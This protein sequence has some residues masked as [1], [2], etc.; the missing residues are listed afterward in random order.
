[1]YS[2]YY[3]IKNSNTDVILEQTRNEIQQP[4]GF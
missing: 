2:D 3:A 1:L 4:P